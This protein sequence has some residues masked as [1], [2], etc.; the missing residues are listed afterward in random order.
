MCVGA[1]LCVWLCV[2]LCLCVCVCVHMC[3]SLLPA[4]KEIQSYIFKRF[5]WLVDFFHFGR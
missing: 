5:A 1:F 4:D 3:I 2:F